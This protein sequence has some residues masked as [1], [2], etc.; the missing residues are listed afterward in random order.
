MYLP[1]KDELIEKEI[2]VLV[3]HLEWELILL[4]KMAVEKK[5]SRLRRNDLEK[6]FASLPLDV[7]P[8]KFAE[9]NGLS[10]D[11]VNYWYLCKRRSA[12]YISREKRN[13]EIMLMMRRGATNRQIANRFDLHPSSVSRIIR[14]YRESVRV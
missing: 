10:I 3:K 1:F 6:V 9:I 11:L 4:K 13:R 8:Q 14:K 12:E 5:R 2:D 7:N